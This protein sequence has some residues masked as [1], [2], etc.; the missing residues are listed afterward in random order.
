MKKGTVTM[1]T[2]SKVLQDVLF[3]G[4]AQCFSITPQGAVASP[5]GGDFL[6][7]SVHVVS[8]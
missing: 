7:G 6:R 3:C 5:R 1:I 2:I 8:I 4:A